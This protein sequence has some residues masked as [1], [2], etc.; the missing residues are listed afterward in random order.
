M[1]EQ[2]QTMLILHNEC[3]FLLRFCQRKQ[4]SVCVEVCEISY[5]LNGEEPPSNYQHYLLITS[6]GCHQW[7]NHAHC[8]EG[9]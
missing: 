6:L 1:E 9:Q 2:E 4:R 7:K 3:S 8:S 5:A